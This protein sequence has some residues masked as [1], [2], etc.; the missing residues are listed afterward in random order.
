M[1]IVIWW[2]IPCKAIAGVIKEL[3][4]NRDV[5]LIVFTGRLSD[6]RR[7]MGWDEITFHPAKHFF[8]EDAEWSTT[9]IQLLETYSSCLHIFG[10]FFYPERINNLINK[11]I[12]RKIRFG[13]F[14]EAPSNHSNG[15]KYLI[16]ELYHRFY[17]RLKYRKIAVASEFIFCLSGSELKQR[18]KLER[19][20]W[21]KDKIIPFG[22]FSEDYNKKLNKRPNKVP[23]IFCPGKLAPHKG[24]DIL[25]KALKIVSDKNL[26]FHCHIT[27]YGS[28][29]KKLIEL[30]KRLNL[31]GKITFHGVLNQLEF[32]IL[33]NEMDI[34]VASGRIEPWGIRINEAIQNGQVVIV[35]DQIGAKELVIA[36]KG[37]KTFKSGNHKDLAEDIIYYLDNP[38]NLEKDQLMNLKYKKRIDPAAISLYVYNT[39]NSLQYKNELPKPEW[40]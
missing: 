27:G 1:Q 24:V 21:S 22:Y 32:N 20:G 39:L 3:S 38:D 18:K 26:H 19:L 25:I 6:E 12:A 9:A 15:F 17:L 10:G 37:G 28:E 35:S 40:L 33:Q 16:T 4:K 13:V 30:V 2:N 23:N 5:S 36:S 29:K 7:Q 14:S 8:L 31:N 11:A 34:L